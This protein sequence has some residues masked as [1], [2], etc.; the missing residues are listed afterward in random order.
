MVA[1]YVPD[2][3]DKQLHSAK[4]EAMPITCGDSDDLATYPNRMAHNKQLSAPP[5]SCVQTIY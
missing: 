1:E 2:I 5:I 3:Q 4:T